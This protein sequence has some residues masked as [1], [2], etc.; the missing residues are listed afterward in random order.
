M[1]LRTEIRQT[2]EMCRHCFMCRHA[3]PTFLVT[4]LDAHTPRGYALA[5]SRVDDGLA[6]WTEDVVSKLYQSTLDGLCSELCEFD[7]R[8]DLVVQA[9]REE[10]VRQGMAP[11]PVI[12]A[13][14]RRIADGAERLASAWLPLAPDRLDRKGA[15]TLFIT[16]LEAR[17]R[18][19]GT[20]VATAALLDHLGADWTVLSIEH[21]P[22]I[23]L[24][25]LGY[26]DAALRAA[27]RFVAEVGRLRPSRIVTGSSRVL[28]ALREPLPSA[29]LA[30]L[31]PVEHLSELLV[32]RLVAR[33]AAA[34]RGRPVDTS[35]IAYH[36]PCSLGRRARVFEPPRQVI[37]A[38]TGAPPLE[39]PH[40]RAL[41]ECCGEGGL[42]PE[43]DPALAARLA[44]ALLTR[45]P[46]GAALVTACPGCRAQLGAAA[47]RAGGSVEVMDISELASSRLGLRRAVDA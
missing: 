35:R 10:A 4:K 38:L 25:E 1:A 32:D 27:E 12:R 3:N 17:E 36:D 6:A 40:S 37:E 2:I 9:G 43:V 42:L 44:S 41:A 19:P 24:W 39:L 7:W 18:S 15:E 26:T 29:A 47:E 21:D 13:A 33:G 34:P 8:E 45:L 46:D 16:G 22:G 5:L 23:D 11:P 30:T 20:I 14:D 31:P 28:R